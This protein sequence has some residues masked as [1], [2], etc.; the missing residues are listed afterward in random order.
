MLNK[1]TSNCKQDLWPLGLKLSLRNQQEV[2]LSGLE[3]VTCPPSIKSLLVISSKNTCWIKLDYRNSFL[4]R[5]SEEI[6]QGYGHKL[7]PD[8]NIAVKTVWQDVI[9]TPQGHNAHYFECIYPNS[10]YK[11]SLQLNKDNLQWP[12]LNK[13][14][15]TRLTE[16]FMSSNGR[17]ERQL[18]CN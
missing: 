14:N 12:N 13:D 16:C 11:Q 9:L 5:I 18:R 4:A 10:P 17:L 2:K 3:K 8:A 1:V 15:L 6:N 7:K